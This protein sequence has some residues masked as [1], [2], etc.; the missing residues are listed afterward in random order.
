MTFAPLF[1]LLSLQANPTVDALLL[2]LETRSAYEAR[3]TPAMVRVVYRPPPSPMEDQTLTPPLEMAGFLLAEGPEGTPTVI[4]P[5]RRLEGVDTVEVHFSSGAKSAGKVQW[6][7]DGR[8]VPLVR[9][10][11]NRV[12]KG[13]RALSWA[14]AD[15]V[16]LGRRA[17]VIE[18]APGKGPGGEPMNP[19]LVD[20]SIG[21]AVEPPLERFLSAKLMQA[22]GLPLLDVDGKILCAIYRSS[23][24]D[25][26]VA[27][28]TPGEWAFDLPT[29]EVE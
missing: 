15:R 8:D 22:D 10:H 25:P 19:V 28:C 5:A 24:V 12:P 26:K 6:P 13:A 1:L 11:L 16:V 21:P 2:D 18:R 14:A 9:V 23:P 3:W 17:W 4:A 7:K 29:K 27:Y 20:T